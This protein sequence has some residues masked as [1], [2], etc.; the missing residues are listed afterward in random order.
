[1]VAPEDWRSL[2]THRHSSGKVSSCGCLAFFSRWIRCCSGKVPSGRCM[3]C[4]AIELSMQVG[5]QEVGRCPAGFLQ[6]EFRQVMVQ[7]VVLS[8]DEC[9]E[10][11]MPVLHDRIAERHPVLRCRSG[12]VL[13]DD[14]LLCV[15]TGISVS[16]QA[17]PEVWPVK[18]EVG[19]PVRGIRDE[20]C[21][22]ARYCVATWSLRRWSG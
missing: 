11:R 3:L 22:T 20:G 18:L 4:S 2:P 17:Y 15:E 9:L 5:P 12:A 7:A 6:D 10:D 13:H 1:M 8:A 19:L 21:A 14:P 16:T